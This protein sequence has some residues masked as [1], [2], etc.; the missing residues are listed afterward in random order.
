MDR[1]DDMIA[2][3]RVVEAKSFTAAAERLQL[4]KSVVSRRLSDLE[5]RLGARLLNRTTRSLSLTP[6]GQAFYERARAIVSAVED[7]EQT[8]AELNREPRG[9]LRVNGPM[10]FGLLHLA[11]AVSEFMKRHPAIEL[12]LELTDRYVDVVEEGWDVAIRIGR[13]PNSSLIARRLAPSRRIVCASPAYLERHGRPEHPDDLARHECL[14][15]TGIPTTGQWPF[16][17]DGELRMVR[18]RGR[19]RVNNADVLAQAALAGLGIAAL[20]TFMIHEDLAAGRLVPILER[21]M[22]QDAAVHAVWPHHRHLSPKVRALVD[23]LADRFGPE[24]YWDA[25]LRDKGLVQP[26][27]P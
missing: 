19:M 21:Q 8:V 16:L 20:P 23:F 7:A 5:E 9:L 26:A 17:I 22:A 27:A 14:L 3:I 4:S 2:F 6:A 13:L 15:Y 18:V 11:A 25:P 12:E 10:S 1:L 24:P